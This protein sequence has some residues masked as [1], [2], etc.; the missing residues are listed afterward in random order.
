MDKEDL[1]T[2]VLAKDV[3][4]W[5]GEPL[6]IF[7]KGGMAFKGGKGN[8]KGIGGD[9]KQSINALKQNKEDRY[10]TIP[11]KGLG[12]GKGSGGNED[13]MILIP[14]K[15]KTCNDVTGSSTTSVVLGY[16]TMRDMME[17]TG[18]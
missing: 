16:K 15:Q 18:I 6:P 13:R 2:R 14:K 12:H 5:Q 9:L 8:G 7:G 17:K 4:V 1:Q 3:A 10:I 11:K